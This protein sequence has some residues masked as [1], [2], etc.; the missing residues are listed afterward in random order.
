MLNTKNFIVLGLGIIGSIIANIVYEWGGVAI[1]ISIIVILLILVCILFSKIRLMDYIGIYRI[2]KN[3]SAGTNTEKLLDK[4]QDNFFLLG[5]GASRFIEAKNFSEALLRV[6]TN[7]IIKFL[8][9]NP[10]AKA[11]KILSKERDVEENHI[12]AV[13]KNSLA[14]I[15]QLKKQGR[16]IEVRYYNN[17]KYIPIFRVVGIDDSELYVSFYNRKETGKKSFQLVLRDNKNDNNLYIAFKKHF[18]F[19]WETAIKA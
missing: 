18:D 19:L 11:P 4:V 3:I 10:E 15:N 5:R 14:T 1:C 13:V 9:L 12:S 7:K 6:D 17:P 2:E 8:I 16:N